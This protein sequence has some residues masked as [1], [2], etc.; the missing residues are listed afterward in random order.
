[1]ENKHLTGLSQILCKAESNSAFCYGEGMVELQTQQEK[2]ELSKRF[3]GYGIVEKVIHNNA[4]ANESRFV[5]LKIFGSIQG[6]KKNKFN[7]YC[8]SRMV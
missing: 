2:R 6:R 8:S 3:F 1:L 7:T 5:S 4:A